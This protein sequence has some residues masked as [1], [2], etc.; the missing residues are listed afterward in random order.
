MEA[1]SGETT[2]LT[3]TT[4]LS[5]RPKSPTHSQPVNGSDELHPRVITTHQAKVLADLALSV[6]QKPRGK[7]AAMDVILAGKTNGL[8]SE[9]FTET[10]ATLV[11]CASASSLG[12]ARGTTIHARGQFQ[13][14]DAS[15]FDRLLP[16]LH[17]PEPISAD[18]L[19]GISIRTVLHFCPQATFAQQEAA[20]EKTVKAVR[21]E[22][23]RTQ[24]DQTLRVN[25]LWGILRFT[26][27]DVVI[28]VG[29]PNRPF[30]E[31]LLWREG[32]PEALTGNYIVK[33]GEY[34]I[35]EPSL[36]AAIDIRPSGGRLWSFQD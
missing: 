32:K 21:D 26:C 9:D 1:I 25:W 8:E 35:V 18:Q 28:D 5:K 23:V 12:L 14:T 17:R 31:I 30:E 22:I 10:M 24:V 27:Q 19:L 6:L 2:F 36:A 13:E 3:S 7:A 20:I 33:P 16:G 34:L 11:K 4:D 15:F 29:E